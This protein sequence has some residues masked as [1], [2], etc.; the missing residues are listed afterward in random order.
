[1]SEEAPNDQQLKKNRKVIL[2]IFGIPAVIILLSTMLYLMV[3]AKVVD[4]GTVNNG[5]L[6]VPPLAFTESPLTGL[7]GE[8]FDYMQPEP[9]WAF[10][11]FGDQQCIESCQQMLYVARQSITALAKNMSRVRLVYVSYEGKIDS[12]LKQRFTDE[13]VG[14]DVLSLNK[15]FLNPLIV[16]CIW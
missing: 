1:M 6:V 3:D 9:K 2:G 4:L 16:K 10:I 7:D 13:Y 11:V 8:H 14:I 15:T 12:A 5:S